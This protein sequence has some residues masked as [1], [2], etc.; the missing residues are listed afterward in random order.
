VAAGVGGQT[1]KNLQNVRNASVRPDGDGAGE[2]F[3]TV[4][5]GLLRLVIRNRNAGKVCNTTDGGG[6]NGHAPAIPEQVKATKF[7]PGHPVL[8]PESTVSC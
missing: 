6:V 2:R 8:Q 5:L 4:A 1:R 3:M 7:T